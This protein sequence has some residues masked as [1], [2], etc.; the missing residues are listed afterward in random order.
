MEIDN[1]L[2]DLDSKFL[3]KVNLFLADAKS[4]GYNIEVFEGFRTLE[5]QKEL[6]AIGRPPTIEH[7][8]PVT[9]TMNSMHL[10]GQAV[11]I[12]FIENN[13]PTWD[14]DYQ[15]LREIANKYEICHFQDNLI[16]LNLQ[17]IMTS[18]FYPILQELINTGYKP[19]FN[20]EWDLTPATLEDVKC[21]IEIGLAR[22][23]TKIGK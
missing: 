3:Q 16:P 7:P 12:V 10:T 17:C 20:T 22:T 5:R 8:R 19:V 13:E 2:N 6:Y 21:L 18:Q 1:S 4:Q 14:W 9:W 15:G 11:D 23:L